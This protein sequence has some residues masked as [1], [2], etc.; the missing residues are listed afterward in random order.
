METVKILNI[1][2]ARYYM[3]NGVNPIRTYIGYNDMIVYEFNRKE[4]TDLFK[5]WNYS[6][7]CQ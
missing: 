6:R 7:I 2:Q 4:T 3:T 1:K 5:K